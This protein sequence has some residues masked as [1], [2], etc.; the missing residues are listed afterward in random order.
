MAEVVVH[1]SRPAEV[2]KTSIEDDLLIQVQE[3]I[4]IL[5]DLGSVM[6]DQY[7]RDTFVLVQLFYKLEEVFS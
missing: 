4:C 6:G 3:L 7:N 5:A 1:F 2:G